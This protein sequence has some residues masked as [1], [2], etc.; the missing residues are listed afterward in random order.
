MLNLTTPQLYRL[1][2]EERLF[3]HLYNKW[4]M[5]SSSD[6]IEQFRTIRNPQ[7]LNMA[8]ELHAIDEY[9]E[10]KFPNGYEWPID[11]WVAW[12]GRW[13]KNTKRKSTREVEEEFN[14]PFYEIMWDHYLK[15]TKFTQREE[16]YRS[17]YARI[18]NIL[19]EGIK[20]RIKHHAYCGSQENRDFTE[21]FLHQY[22]LILNGHSL[23]DEL[24]ARI[25]RLLANGYFDDEKF[26]LY[27]GR[28]ASDLLRWV[29]DLK[30]GPE[31]DQCHNVGDYAFDGRRNKGGLK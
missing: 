11:S 19:T 26:M 3:V 2:V 5:K 12:I 1:S 20:T 14:R 4:G 10:K 9:L 18:W 29:L 28:F 8:F 6:P 31:Y 30:Y 16:P 25:E 21:V 15:T 27:L 24:D 13:M 17:Q 23:Y 22:Q 7:G